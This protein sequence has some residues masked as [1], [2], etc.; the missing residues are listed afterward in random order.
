MA[1]FLETPKV[2]FL[3]FRKVGRKLVKSRSKIGF[4]AHKPIFDLLLTYFGPTFRNVSKPTFDLLFAYIAFFFSGF[5]GFRRHATSQLKK[6]V[7]G[8]LTLQKLQQEQLKFLLSLK[9]H[10]VC[11]SKTWLTWLPSLSRWRRIRMNTHLLSQFPE[12]A[13][14]RVGCDLG[15]GGT[16]GDRCNVEPILD[17]HA[18]LDSKRR[19]R[20]K[21]NGGG[22]GHKQ[23]STSQGRLKLFCKVILRRFQL[24]QASI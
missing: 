4:S 20:T 8:M 18:S 3:T 24:K 15:K 12:A 1:C 10:R 16:G 13:I 14:T 6:I 21:I 22:K 5:W 19:G 17:A 7:N 2:G 11:P 23:L 9:S